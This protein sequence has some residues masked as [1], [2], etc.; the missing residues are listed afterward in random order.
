MHSSGN[1][2]SST[3]WVSTRV[4]PINCSPCLNGCIVRNSSR[5]R[6]SASRTSSASFIGTV[7]GLG[8]KARSTPAQHF[9]FQSRSKT[10]AGGRP[11]HSPILPRLRSRAH[12]RG[13]DR[14][15][16]RRADPKEALI[17]PPTHQPKF[18]GIFLSEEDRKTTEY[19]GHSGQLFPSFR[20]FRGHLDYNPRFPKL[21]SSARPSSPC[22][23][24]PVSA[25]MC[26]FS[27][28]RGA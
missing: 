12:A 17:H 26:F 1:L 10:K 7:A 15:P 11:W 4:L 28:A 24:S 25:E 6:A 22:N 13:R 2:P 9:I 23:D 5:V 8:R 18:S 20:V 27:A 14:T 21:P 3:E 19:R 16:P